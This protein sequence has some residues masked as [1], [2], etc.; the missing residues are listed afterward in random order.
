[1][2]KNRKMKE[3]GKTIG[4][5]ERRSVAATVLFML[6][7]AL[8]IWAYYFTQRNVIQR[9]QREFNTLLLSIAENGVRAN[10]RADMYH[11]DH[12]EDWF[13][14]LI[15]AVGLGEICLRDGSGA[16][17]VRTVAPETEGQTVRYQEITG[18]LAQF[19]ALTP[20]GWRYGGPRGRGG[21]VGAGWKRLPPGPYTFSILVNQDPW[22]ERYAL[23]RHQMILG[24]ILV[25]AC[26]ILVMSVFSYKMRQR[27]LQEE[28]TAAQADAARQAML[29]AMGSGLAH[30]TK[31]P[32]GLIRGMAQAIVDRGETAPETRDRAL[33]IID[34]TDRVAGQID[35][36]LGMAK[37]VPTRNEPVPLD[38]LFENIAVLL[39]DEAAAAS[40][41]FIVRPATLTVIADP[42]RL[43]KA[44]LNL[45][46]NAFKACKPGDSV[47]LYAEQ[48]DARH[49]ALVIED[50]GCG[51][52]PEDLAHVT[53][54]YFHKFAEGSGLGLTIT[55][56]IVQ[57]FG[58]KLELESLPGQG[59]TA[60]LANLSLGKMSH[61]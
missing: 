51:I 47:T 49:A 17:M 55:S 4:R 30:E 40:I 37:P 54:P 25:F 6:V 52:A 59:V 53:E 46:L 14:G 2:K 41:S 32:L 57:G 19:E 27:W 22:A 48:T 21:G 36:F 35:R 34:E 44:I 28:L 12:L 45:A 10:I 7:A 50:T 1:M 58:G 5:L 8:A 15:A 16:D 38:K 20:P 39:R 11:P 29:A 18:E 31:N 3:N 23:L 24:A 43:R 13:T 9:Q 42:E 33:R 26:V 61:E 56:E 60:R